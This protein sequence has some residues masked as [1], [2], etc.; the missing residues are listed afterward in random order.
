MYQAIFFQT[1]SKGQAHHQLYTTKIEIRLR[2]G[3]RTNL[4]KNIKN[5]VFSKNSQTNH[6][7]IYKELVELYNTYSISPPIFFVQFRLVH[8]EICGFL[9]HN[10]V[11]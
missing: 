8:L 6:L 1:F 3:Y 9:A 2:W 10:F 5:T 7:K 4:Q 11:T